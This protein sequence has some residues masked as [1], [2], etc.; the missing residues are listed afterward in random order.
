MQFFMSQKTECEIISLLSPLLISY[1]IKMAENT[2]V[3]GVE[4][5]ALIEKPLDVILSEPYQEFNAAC[6][7][8]KTGN[9]ILILSSVYKCS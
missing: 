1:R 9:Y 2:S 5:E 4:A 6:R 7:A 8:L 3:F